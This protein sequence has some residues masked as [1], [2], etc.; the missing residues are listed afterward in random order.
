MMK[1]GFVIIIIIL[2]VCIFALNNKRKELKYKKSEYYIQTKNTYTNVMK[3][4]GHLGE[5]LIYEQ[6]KTLNGYKKFLFNVYVPKMNGGTTEIDV[7]LLHES[8]V[9]VFESKNY[10]G[11]IF[12]NET[13]QYWTQTLRYGRYGIQKNKFINPIRQNMSH[14]KWLQYF[15]KEEPCLTFYSYIVFSNRCLLKDVTITSKNHFVINRYD[16]FSAVQINAFHSG[17][18]LTYQTIDRLY[19]KLY[20][21]TQLDDEQKMEHIKAIWRNRNF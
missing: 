3:D 15:L 19:E 18:Q 6:L 2:F 16:V 9:Y 1:T 20:P 17:T 11:W 4:K 21:L 8:G 14:L 7:I 5:F 13:Q 12:G 10:S